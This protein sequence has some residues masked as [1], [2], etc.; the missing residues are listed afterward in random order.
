MLQYWQHSR[1]RAW[2]ASS[3]YPYSRVPK[4]SGLSCFIFAW[5]KSQGV[6]YAQITGGPGY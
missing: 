2:P 1:R 5:S 4:C 6:S 3:R